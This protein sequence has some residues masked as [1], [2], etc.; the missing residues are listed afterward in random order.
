MSSSL[1]QQSIQT[2]NQFEYS[3]QLEIASLSINPASFSWSYRIFLDHL[4]VDENPVPPSLKCSLPEEQFWI[5]VSLSWQVQKTAPFLWDMKSSPIAISLTSNPDSSHLLNILSLMDSA[6]PW[7]K[8]PDPSVFVRWCLVCI[9][10][11]SSLPSFEWLFRY[12]LNPPWYLSRPPS[13]LSWMNYLLYPNTITAIALGKMSKDGC[14]GDSH[15]V[16][17]WDKTKRNWRLP[18]SRFPVAVE[19]GNGCSIA[20]PALPWRPPNLPS[21]PL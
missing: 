7:I 13:Y 4:L 9:F 15:S 5:L 2:A 8:F 18:A 1:A 14:M 3:P 21:V 20:T 16:S 10:Q 17:Y 19:T 11:E 12:P 6:C